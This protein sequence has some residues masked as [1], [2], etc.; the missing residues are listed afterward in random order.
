MKVDSIVIAKVLTAGAIAS[1]AAVSWKVYLL[2]VPKFFED[3]KESSAK[4]LK[5]F[6]EMYKQ[7]SPVQITLSVIGTLSSLYVAYKTKDRR[8]LMVTSLAALPASFTIAWLGPQVNE[9]LF[10]LEENSDKGEVADTEQVETLLTKWKYAHL[11]RAVVPT[12][13]LAALYSLKPFKHCFCHLKN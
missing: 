5:S 6:T 1:F 13:A 3:L 11:G 12:I 2:D 10:K 9:K 4:S 7:T 8:W